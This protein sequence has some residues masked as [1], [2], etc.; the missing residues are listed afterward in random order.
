MTRL[1]KIKWQASKKHAVILIIHLI[2]FPLCHRELFC[3]SSENGVFFLL[4][5][6]MQY[7]KQMVLINI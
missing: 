4:V 7:L 6:F 5:L 1:Q 3:G 2:P